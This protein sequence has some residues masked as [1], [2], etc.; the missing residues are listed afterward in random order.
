[1]FNV[2]SSTFSTPTFQ[3]NVQCSECATLCNVQ[4]QGN[5]GEENVFDTPS[6]TQKSCDRFRSVAPS[7]IHFHTHPLDVCSHFL[8]PLGFTYTRIHSTYALTF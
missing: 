4:R 5:C 7:G 3:F 1:M 2:Q 6:T 8:L